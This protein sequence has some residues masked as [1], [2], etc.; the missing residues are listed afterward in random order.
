MIE[1][2]RVHRVLAV[3]FCISLFA[4]VNRDEKSSS[5]TSSTT[6]PLGAATVNCDDMTCNNFHGA[7]GFTVGRAAAL[8]ADF[9]APPATATICGDSSAV[10]T[11]YYATGDSP[12]DT[13]KF[14][15]KQLDA[16]GFHLK[17]HFPGVKKCSMQ[18]TFYKTDVEVGTL[19][20]YSGGFSITYSTK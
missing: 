19:S 1:G 15:E 16:A 6:S 9:P 13:I 2:C 10:H 20:A 11:N 8:P 4:C 18:L 17:P 7:P 14:Y 12:S 3:A 5:Q